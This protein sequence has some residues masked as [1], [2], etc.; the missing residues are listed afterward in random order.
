MKIKTVVIIPARMASTRLPGKPLLDIG[1]KPL[2][3]HVYERATRL[4]IIDKVVVATDSETIINAVGHF[5]GLS[6]LTPSNIKTGSDRC[7]IAA[8]ECFINVTTII[9]IQGDIPFFNVDYVDWMIDMA[10][11]LPQGLVS[12]YCGVPEDVAKSTSC[13]KVVMNYKRE[14]LYFS[15]HMIS[16]S[17]DTEEY[18]KHIGI[19][20]WKRNLLERFYHQPQP[21]FEINEKLEQLRVLYMG[22]KIKMLYSPYDFLSIDTPE[23]LEAARKQV[24]SIE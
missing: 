3:Q 13:V 22:E 21:S 19:Y 9:N 11:E 6:V 15:R 20:I 5:D 10:K 16:Y 2:I 8:K 24:K 12:A 4:K 1:G 17:N 14:A 18:K 23:D 7:Y